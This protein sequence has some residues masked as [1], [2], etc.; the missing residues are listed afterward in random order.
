MAHEYNDAD[1]EYEIDSAQRQGTT[2]QTRNRRH[3]EVSCPDPTHNQEAKDKSQQ[4]D[5]N[6]DDFGIPS[7]I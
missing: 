6:P 4:E 3:G 5:E 7:W 2:G 1:W